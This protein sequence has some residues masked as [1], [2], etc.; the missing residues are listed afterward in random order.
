[1]E[2][3]QRGL[4]QLRRSR[5]MQRVNR[6]ADA[7]KLLILRGWFFRLAR[8]VTKT[9]HRDLWYRDLRVHPEDGQ[10]IQGPDLHPLPFGGGG[11]HATGS[12]AKDDLFVGR[13]V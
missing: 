1:M 11:E 3:C 7:C 8:I 10:T 9:R 13:P 2:L 5:S 6:Q 4:A 12:K